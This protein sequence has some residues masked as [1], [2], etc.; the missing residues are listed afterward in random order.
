MMFTYYTH[1][2]RSVALYIPSIWI[3]IP[4]RN[5]SLSI[6]DLF[7]ELFDLF[8]CASP[9]RWNIVI[10]DDGSE[11]NTVE[12]C[13]NV[14]TSYTNNKVYNVNLYVLSLTRHFGKEIALK[15]AIDFVCDNAQKNDVDAVSI[16]DADLQEPPNLILHMLTEW[17]KG[18]DLILARRNKKCDSFIRVCTSWLFYKT[19]SLLGEKFILPKCGDFKL[20]DASVAKAVSAC[21]DRLS[22]SKGLFARVSCGNPIIL[23][24]EQ[25]PRKNGRSKFHLLSLL[26]LAW[27]AFVS[28]TAFYSFIGCALA[29]IGFIVLI[30]SLFNI[31]MTSQYCHLCAPLSLI[32]LGCLLDASRRILHESQ[33][34]PLYVLKN[35]VELKAGGVTYASDGTH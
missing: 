7:S 34:Y 32:G 9:Y 13:V 16:I 25:K 20:F 17:E 8:S 24:Y 5:E 29:A 10:A 11:D 21:S 6:K 19:L 28:Y 14:F 23:D 15:A 12:S 3:I 18:N 22:W 33:H 27:N 35:I 26:R 4:C 1:G 2:K 30:L 31:S